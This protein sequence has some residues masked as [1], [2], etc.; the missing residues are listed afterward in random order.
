MLSPFIGR[1]MPLVAELRGW[2]GGLEI[3]TGPR[4]PQEWRLLNMLGTLGSFIVAEASSPAAA[5]G[6]AALPVGQLLAPSIVLILCIF[7]G[8]GTLLLLPSRRDISIR[9]IGGAVLAAAALIFAALVLRAEAGVGVYFWIFSA[10][11]LIGAVRVITHSRPVYSALYFVLTVFASAGLFVLLQAEFMAAALVLIY[12]GAI[13]ITYVFVIMLASQARAP[14]STASF[15]S[16]YDTV[17]REPLIASMVGFALMGLLLMVIFDRAGTMAPP[18]AAP[19]EDPAMAKLQIEGNTQKLGVY[20]FQNQ[21]ISLELAGLILTVSMVGAIVIARKRVVYHEG[22]RT[23]GS[24]V[25]IAP[26]TPIDDNPFSIPVYGT[27][28]PGQKAYPE[29]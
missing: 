5:E 28:N 19:A 22:I 20:L 6:S 10:I 8:V 18:A 24:D 13:L 3:A 4:K 15:L 1:L 12:A 21:P 26:A 25:T 27:D 14:G 2:P 11:A 29:T 9:R 23:A 7:A 16:E 17:S